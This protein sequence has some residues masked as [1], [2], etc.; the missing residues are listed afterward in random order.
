M[1][2]RHLATWLQLPLVLALFSALL[3]WFGE[4][5]GPV[6]DACNRCATSK[7]TVGSFAPA[8]MCSN[9]YC[10]ACSSSYPAEDEGA[11]GAMH[12]G[13]SRVTLSRYRMAF[14]GLLAVA[15][16]LEMWAAN[17]VLNLAGRLKQ[18]S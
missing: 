2:C 15:T 13:G 3:G 18:P 12:A 10:S 8:D 1:S 9:C 16:A 4:R 17:V 7:P 14:I 6:A 5:L 11:C